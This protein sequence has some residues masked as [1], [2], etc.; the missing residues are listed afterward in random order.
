MVS[1]RL[2]L[3]DSSATGTPISSSSRRTYLMHCAGSS[4]PGARTAGRFGP[5]FHGLVD[6]FDAG[7][8]TLRGGKIIELLAVELIA[9]ADLELAARQIIEHVELGQRDAVD[10]ADF[11]GLAHEAGVEPA[12]AARAPRDRAE[13]RPALAEQLADLVVE[14][15]RERPLAH[16]RRVGLGDA[17][18][19]VEGAGA[20]ARAGRRLRRHRV[21][22]GDERIGAVV[23]VEQRALRAFEQDPL[24]RAALASSSAH[25]VST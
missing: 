15:G 22:R 3:V 21:R 18:H 19:V 24:A 23:D 8:R 5:A 6:R 1:S 17:E 14:L 9:D 25:T 20:D 11:T 16:A 2:G 12:A 13:L 7:L 10:A 4:R